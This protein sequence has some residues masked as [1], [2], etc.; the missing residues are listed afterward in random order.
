VTAVTVGGE[1]R[2]LKALGRELRS[3]RVIINVEA[4]PDSNTQHSL[5]SFVVSNCERCGDGAYARF[6]VSVLETSL[7]TKRSPGAPDPSDRHTDD[8]ADG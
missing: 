5:W 2:L 6:G 3:P 1:A 7:G 4:Y 8:D